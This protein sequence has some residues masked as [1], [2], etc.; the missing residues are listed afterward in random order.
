MNIPVLYA[1][2]FLGVIYLLIFARN[3]YLSKELENAKKTIIVYEKDDIRQNMRGEYDRLK[4]DDLEEE[5]E[6]LKK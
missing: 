3:N 4:I 6:E 2:V 5:I 1:Q